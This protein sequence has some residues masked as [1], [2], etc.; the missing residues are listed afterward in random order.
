MIFAGWYMEVVLSYFDVTLWIYICVSLWIK[1]SYGF[2]FRYNGKA[3]NGQ[4]FVM[5]HEV[6]KTGAAFVLILVELLLDLSLLWRLELLLNHWR[7]FYQKES[8]F[9]NWGDSGLRGSGIR[10]MPMALPFNVLSMTWFCVLLDCQWWFFSS[11]VVAVSEALLVGGC[12]G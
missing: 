3:G 8:L 4:I 7:F 6:V 10:L 2:K 9:A 1:W 5:L 12:R 11:R